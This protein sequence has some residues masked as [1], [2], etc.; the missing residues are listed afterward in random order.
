MDQKSAFVFF[1]QLNQKSDCILKLI[2]ENGELKMSFQIWSKSDFTS[3]L[4]SDFNSILNS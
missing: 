2:F 1:W 3:G 4:K